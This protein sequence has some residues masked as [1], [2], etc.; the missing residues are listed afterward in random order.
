MIPSDMC[1]GSCNGKRENCPSPQ[2]CGWPKYE[3]KDKGFLRSI[4]FILMMLGLIIFC[5]GVLTW[6]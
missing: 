6:R 3:D 5:V 1:S 4:V 2:A